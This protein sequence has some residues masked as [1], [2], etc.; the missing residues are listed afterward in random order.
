MCT[1]LRSGVSNVQIPAAIR[2]YQLIPVRWLH[3]VCCV[4]PLHGGAHRWRA[5]PVVLPGH[6]HDLCQWALLPAATAA[7]ADRTLLAPL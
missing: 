7:S 5:D 6:P 3:V 4:Q 1:V 2:L